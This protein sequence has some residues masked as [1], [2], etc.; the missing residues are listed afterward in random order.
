MHFFFYEQLLCGFGLTV[1]F[2]SLLGLA[3]Y[4][5]TTWF[6]SFFQSLL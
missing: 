4:A 2:Q 5:S 1:F 6:D 3:G